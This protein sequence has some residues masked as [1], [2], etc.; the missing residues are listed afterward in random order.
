ML[1]LEEKQAV[2]IKKWQALRKAPIKT[3]V[4]P[5]S[6][7]PTSTVSTD[8]LNRSDKNIENLTLAIWEASGRDLKSLVPPGVKNQSWYLLNLKEPIKWVGNLAI[9]ADK[10]FDG[11]W[12]V[13]PPS[14]CMISYFGPGAYERAM[15]MA[16][17]IRSYY[18]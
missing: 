7:S 9:G 6:P 2:L 5:S 8:I 1:S 16:D 14:G 10:R 4:K 3:A 12:N 17:K 15:E 18:P 13:V 11:W